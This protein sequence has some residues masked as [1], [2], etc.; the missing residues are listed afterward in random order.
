MSIKLKQLLAK[1]GK[2][3]DKMDYTSAGALFEQAVTL[4][5][6]AHRGWYGL[7]E[8]ASGIGQADTA[9]SF[10]GHAA[11]LQPDNARYHQRLGET[12]GRLGQVKDGLAHLRA[13]RRLAPRDTGVLCSLSGGYVK[14]GNWHKA[15][16]ILL[17]VVRMPHPQ[18]AHYC[19]LGLACQCLGE[20]DEALTA[21]KKATSLAPH[22]PDAWVSL[23]HLYIQK[24]VLDKAGDALHTLFTLVPTATSTFDLAGDLALTR[25]DTQEAAKFF[26]QA[27]D[28]APEQRD[29]QSKLAITQV[30]N[31]DALA[32]IDTMERLHALGA[33]D[34]WILEKLGAV[35][36]LKYWTPMARE[37][38]EMAVERNPDN[39]DAWNLLLAVY[40]RSGE[41]EKVRKA[42]D[43]LL[44]KD[45]DNIAAMLHLATW[46]NDQGRHDEA[47]ALLDRART[48]QPS[49]HT[50][51]SKTLWTLVSASSASAADILSV[52]RAMDEHIFRPHLRG[53]DFADR[54]RNPE[55]RLRIGWLSSDMRRHPVSAFVQPFLPHLDRERLE[56]FVYYNFSE[57]DAITR[58]IKQHADHWRTVVGIGDD[59][60]A[61]LIE[62]DEIDILVDLNGFT[63]GGRTDM[64]ARKPAPIQASWLGFPGTSGMTAMDYILTPPDPVLE[65]GEWCSETPWPLPDCYGVRADISEAAIAPGLPCERLQTPFTFA[66]LNH[67][68]KASEKTIELWSRILVRLPEARMIL[69]AIGGKDDDTIRYFTGQFERHG[70]DPRQLAFRGYAPRQQYYESY[71]EIDLGL[72]PFPFNGGTTGYDSIWM[73]VPFVTWPGEH[74]CARM[75]K[76]ILE[77]AGLHELVADSAEAYVDIAVRLAHDRERLKALRAGLRERMLASP[78]LD[79]PRMARNLETAFRGM[80]RRW[81]AESAEKQTPATNGATT[82]TD[83]KT[84]KQR[85]A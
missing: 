19:L 16:S 48:R 8:V 17:E 81:C 43:T 85:Q 27:A 38:L 29:I 74:L 54:D 47:L 73:G 25:G 22:Y 2:A 10:F 84:R 68:R 83:A 11:Q 32:A 79:A 44:E 9:A 7:G 66:C 46:Y 5:P 36:T 14:A 24:N 63:D 61:D 77:N 57:E 62:G 41:S 40:T 71:N 18:A 34:D 51:Y 60:L 52:A 76:A 35:F 30:M 58:Q 53:N 15:K 70:V 72:D 82:D 21:F 39:I 59:S 13:A 56:I 69:V 33:S 75:G 3:L 55:R 20:L 31:G 50:T 45:P 49:A 12:L 4:S 67:F 80:W 28:S 23:C 6:Q 65:K 78:L 64:V 1:A 26:K 42:A 37:S